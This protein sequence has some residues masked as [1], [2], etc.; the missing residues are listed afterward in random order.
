MITAL[1]IICGLAIMLAAFQFALKKGKQIL[2]GLL[3]LWFSL[4][5]AGVMAWLIFQ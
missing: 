4:A 1:L 5:V 3:V 2:V